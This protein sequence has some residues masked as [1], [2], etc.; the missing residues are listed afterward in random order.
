M[1]P[2]FS[3]RK[4]DWTSFIYKFES[5]VRVIAQGGNLSDQENL[6]LLNS[7]LP[8]S[9]QREMQLWERERG[10]MPSFVEFRAYLEAKFGRAQSENMRKKWLGVQMSKN[11]GKVTLQDF[12]EFRV[13]FKLALADVLDATPEVARRVLCDKLPPFMRKWV[14]DL[15]AK[16]MKK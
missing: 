11:W 10:R 7:C 15:E 3:N 16:R 8:E 1:S 13:S 5:W 14:M 12:D 2:K 4:E 6:L 9:L